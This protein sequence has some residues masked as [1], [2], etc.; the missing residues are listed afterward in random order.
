MTNQKLY[1]GAKLREIRT[2]IGLTQTAFAAKLGVS[3][4]Y[5][6]QMENNHRPVST[7]VVLALAGE[8]G[9]DVTELTS[10]DTERLVSDIREA[11]ADP[12]FDAQPPLADLRLVASNAPMLARA[13]LDLHRAYRQ[14]HE[15]LASLDEALGREDRR[16][17]PSPWEE[18]RDFFHY[19]DNYLDAIDRAA[20]RVARDGIDAAAEAALAARK[21]VVR[22]ADTGTLRHYDPETRV[23]T[24]SAR[25]DL[26]TRRFQLFH[27]AALLTQND[28]LEATLDLAR[29]QSDAA[30]RHR[31]GWACELFPGGVASMMPYARF[32]EGRG[33]RAARHRTP[34]PPP[35]KSSPEQVGHRLSNAPAAARAK[36]RGPLL[37]R[38]GRP[39][40]HDHQ[41]ALGHAPSNFARFGRRLPLCGMCTAP[42][43]HRAGC[44]ASLAETPDPACAISASRWTS[45]APVGA[46]H[47]PLRRFRDRARLRDR[48]TRAAN[49]LRRRARHHQR[50]TRSNPSAFL[51][52]LRADRLP[53]AVGPAARAS[54][55]HRHRPAGRSALTRFAPRRPRRVSMR[56]KLRPSATRGA[57]EVPPRPHPTS[58]RDGVSARCTAWFT[59]S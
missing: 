20:E 39:G 29:F 28:L 40:R 10:G 9:V 33:G 31:Q 26:P 14:S 45:P 3:L 4:P 25:A 53:P 51:Q 42:S 35:S 56:L 32:L 43:R 6:N 16:T 5:L 11:L 41:S 23:L 21:V 57:C 18:V 55:H 46:F 34:L 54:A 15:R 50:S 2:R 36:G 1:A 59:S 8:F 44:C 58:C 30:R 22:L 52:D 47:A 37:L 27:Q 12:V 24:L 17:V 19:C 38:A 49:R 48:N 13:F 7:G